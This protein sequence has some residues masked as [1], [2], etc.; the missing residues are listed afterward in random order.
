MLFVVAP[1]S[2]TGGFILGAGISLTATQLSTCKTRQIDS[3][4]ELQ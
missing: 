2:G 1:A 4:G 3:K